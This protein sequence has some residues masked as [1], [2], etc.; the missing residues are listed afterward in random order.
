MKI[1]LERDY[2]RG[3]PA[4]LALLKAAA[5]KRLTRKPG[6]QFFQTNV[7]Y[8][9]HQHAAAIHPF[10]IASR[11]IL[12][13]SLFFG[14]DD[15]AERHAP[16]MIFLALCERCAHAI[17]GRQNLYAKENRLGGIGALDLRRGDDVGDEVLGRAQA[18]VDFG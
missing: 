4:T 15:P 5:G 13:A 11:M 18:D 1:V 17:L 10:R 7:Q 16:G 14:I 9:S 3:A 8:A 12:P 6:E 2:S